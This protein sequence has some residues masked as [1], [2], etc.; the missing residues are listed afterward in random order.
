MLTAAGAPQDSHRQPQPAPR[1]RSSNYGCLYLHCLK[2]IA[3]TPELCQRGE[4]FQSNEQNPIA[5]QSKAYLLSPSGS[6]RRPPVR[7]HARQRSRSP[8]GA[9]CLKEVITPSPS[10]A[11]KIRSDKFTEELPE[12]PRR[13]ARRRSSA[14]SASRLPPTPRRDCGHRSRSPGAAGTPRPCPARTSPN[15]LRRGSPSPGGGPRGTR[16]RAL[17]SAPPPAP[18]RSALTRGGSRGPAPR[19]ELSAAPPLRL[20]PE[21]GPRRGG[22]AGMGGAG[23]EPGGAGRAAPPA[24]GP[25]LPGRCGA[26]PLRPA[27]F[28]GDAVRGAGG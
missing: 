12:L 21:V 20:R 14:R 23:G 3:S 24:P 11:S 25:D 17:R 5:N 10:A 9:N 15:A 4:N 16:H 28:R 13:A 27:A 6:A 18:L 26:V 22:G 2:N 1:C 8:L 19:S 7:R